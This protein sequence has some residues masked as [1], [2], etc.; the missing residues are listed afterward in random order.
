M[1]PFFQVVTE[2]PACLGTRSFA[3]ARTCTGT[4]TGTGL[5]PCAEGSAK[6]NTRLWPPQS[7]AMGTSASQVSRNSAASGNESILL[8]D[9]GMQIQIWKLPH[10]QGQCVLWNAFVTRCLQHMQFC[11]TNANCFYFPELENCTDKVCIVNVCIVRECLHYKHCNIQSETHSFLI[12]FRNENLSGIAGYKQ[13][14]ASC[15]LL[16][17]ERERERYYCRFRVRY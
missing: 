3:A 17:I 7:V 5:L 4:A 12:N 10:I 16:S 6:E 11:M 15:S 1:R 14:I 8:F 13:D 2:P 9:I